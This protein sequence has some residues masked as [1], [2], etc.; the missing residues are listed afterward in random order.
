MAK[1]QNA[2]E[3]FKLLNKSNCQECG[4]KTC[5]AF[6]GAVFQSRRA[7]AD[8][9]YLERAVVERY[10]DGKGDANPADTVRED[11]L[12]QLKSRIRDI[13]FSQ[14]AERIGGQTEN[15]KLTIRIMG[16]NFSVDREGRLYADIHVN[17]WVAVPFLEYVL[18]AQGRS[19]EGIWVP[20]RELP[21]GKERGP[22]FEKRCETP[23]KQLADGLPDFFED[24]IHMFSGRQ[25]EAQFESD[26][27][28]VLDPLPKVPLM[29][30][31]WKADEGLDSS[32]NLF[33]DETATSNLSIG[34]IYTLAA[35]LS[36]MFSRLGV[37]HGVAI[38]G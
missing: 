36:Q 3:I 10:T 34:S 31:Y 21:G 29:I 37:R 33:F 35:G 7:I 16:K 28:V 1:A 26:I 19:P 17:P 6:A 32:L 25:V 2:M 13:D 30:S 24:I 18:D 22:L 15:G 5:L 23:M 20:F 9:P 38:N 27:S 11:Y 4:E 14:T 12:Q 8:C